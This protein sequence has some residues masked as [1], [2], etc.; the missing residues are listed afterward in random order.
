MQAAQSSKHEDTGTRTKIFR[1]A[2]QLFARR[3]YNGVSMREISEATGLSKPTIYYYFGSKEGIYKELLNVSLE[4]GLSL[5]NAIVKKDMPVKQKLIEIVKF[6]FHQGQEYPEF[7]KFILTLFVASERLPFLDHF[8]Q[9]AENRR[10]VL[11]SLV[12]E[13]K[14]KGE[15]GVNVQAELTAEILLGTITH[16]LWRQIN[17]KKQILSDE[18]AVEIVELLFKGL[19]E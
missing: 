9:E 15:F 5:F 3:G 1:T 4:Q 12:Q 16:F 14:D 11:I 8:I 2:A 18:L 7:V 17:C 6:R 10:K 19:N 13:G